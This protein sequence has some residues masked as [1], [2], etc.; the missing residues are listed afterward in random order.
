MLMHSLIR[1]TMSNALVESIRYDTR[2]R[3]AKTTN[4]IRKHHEKKLDMVAFMTSALEIWTLKF[5]SRYISFILNSL[6][7]DT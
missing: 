5:K 1:L 6:R 7:T 4:Q 3:L 2:F